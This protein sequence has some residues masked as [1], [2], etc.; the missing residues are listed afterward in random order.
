MCFVIPYRIQ[1]RNGNE[2]TLE[3]GRIIDVNHNIS[4]EKGNYVRLAGDS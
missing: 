4:L 2:T 3:D 1:K